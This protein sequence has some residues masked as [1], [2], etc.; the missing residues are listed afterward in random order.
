MNGRGLLWNEICASDA[1]KSFE[2]FLDKPNLNEIRGRT[3][4]SGITSGLSQ[5]S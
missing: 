2:A 3:Q 1:I 4:I 5:A